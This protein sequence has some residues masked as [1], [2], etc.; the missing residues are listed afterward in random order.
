MKVLI[1]C[2]SRNYQVYYKLCEVLHQKYP[3][4]EFG[5]FSHVTESDSLFKGS[6]DPLFNIYDPFNE[7]NLGTDYDSNVTLIKAFEDF[8]ETTIWK[9]ITADR[10]I[11]W[12]D[13]VGN[14]GTYI[15]ENM[16]S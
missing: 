10:Y 11:G 5:Y 16:R 3:E 8:S 13:H 1:E 14:Y 12:S 7:I 9:M 4:A 15:K 6:K 2:A